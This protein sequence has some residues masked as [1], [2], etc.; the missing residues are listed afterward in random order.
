MLK[1]VLININPRIFQQYPCCLF[2]RTRH[3]RVVAHQ[4]LC[5]RAVD[6]QRKL[7]RKRFRIGDLELPQQIA[8]PDATAFLEGDRRLLH[9]FVLGAEFGDRID[10]RAAA[11]IFGCKTP[12][13][14]I[15]GG[16]NLLDRRLVRRPRLDEAAREVGCDQ[17]VLGRKMVV[18]RALAD[19]DLGR[20]G[21]DAD[22]ADALQI[23][24]AVGGLQNPLFH[25]LLCKRGGHPTDSTYG[26]KRGKS[27][28]CDTQ[29]ICQELSSRQA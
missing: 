10:E 29:R 25:R 18:E 9:R 5:D 3:R 24:Q 2:R 15:E 23:E 6:Q 14:R 13:Q 7:C 16:E 20:D 27:D 28:I 21:V 12:L 8:E 22:G 11:K 19:A 4:I 1:I 26:F 17:R